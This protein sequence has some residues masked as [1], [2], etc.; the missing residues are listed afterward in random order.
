MRLTLL[1]DL[2]DTLLD[3]DV[4]VFLP[5]YIQAFSEFVSDIIEPEK[6]VGSLMAGTQH[7]VDNA[8]PDCTLGEVFESVFFPMS[9]LDRTTFEDKI[10]QFYAQVF[11]RLEE[12]TSPVPDAVSFI[13]SARARGYRIVIATNP[14]FPMTAILQR[15]AWAGLPHEAYEFDL[16]A[17]LETFHFVKPNPAFF[18]ETLGRLGWPEGPVAVVGDDPERDIAAAKQLGLAAFWID[19]R[20]SGSTNDSDDPAVSGDMAK[21]MPW[22]DSKTNGELLPDYNAVSAML[23]IL[24]STP[25]VLDSL[26]RRVSLDAWT[27]RPRSEEWCPTEIVCHFR[28]VEGEV[29]LRRIR[30]VLMGDNPFL[31]GEDTDPWADERT[32]ICQNGAQ[33]LRDFT[34]TRMQLLEMLTNIPHE[35]WRRPARHSIFGRTDLKELVSMIAGHDRMHIKQLVRDLG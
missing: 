25:A 11:P 5:A 22:L 26:L 12:Y 29:N 16:V 19:H 34:T 2:D 18:A 27:E 23:A 9:G 30:N 17:S 1:M 28:D 20:N 31:T 24:R 13:D 7:M 33:A 10:D 6:F 15:L 3:N 21:L 35:D 14:L 8:L 32:Y 4:N